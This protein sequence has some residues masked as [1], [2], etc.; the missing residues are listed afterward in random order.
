MQLHEDWPHIVR[1]AWSVRF[2]ALA[3][4]LSVI[5]VS[6]PIIQPYVSINPVYVGGAAGIAAGAAFFARIVAQKEFEE[7]VGGPST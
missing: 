5:E 3:F 6:L 1:H 2:I 4:L 7:D